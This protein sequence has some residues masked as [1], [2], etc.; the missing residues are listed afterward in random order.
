MA[1]KKFK[2]S[3]SLKDLLGRELVTDKYVAIFELVKNASDADATK[4]I[5]QF[6][7]NI[8]GK[9]SKIIIADNG[10]G[11]NA[12]D[13]ND[14]WLFVGYSDK[15]K[16]KDSETYVVSNK[17]NREYAGA[18]GVGRFSCDRL[19]KQLQMLTRQ[20][21]DKF[22][23]VLINWGDFEKNSLEEFGNVPISHIV[24]EKGDKL[25]LRHG[26]ILEISDLRDN[27]TRKDLIT[28]RRHLMKLVNP[29]SFDGERFSIEMIVPQEISEDTK[30]TH[31]YEKVNG[32]IKNFVLEKLNLKTI[33]I[34][35]SIDDK[36]QV[37]TTTLTDR[38]KEIYSVQEVNA[39]FPLL[40]N[41]DASIYHLNS[42][43]KEGFY[44]A[45]SLYPVNFGSIFVYKNGFR[46][47]PYGE[48]GDDT[49]GIDHRKQQGFLR[50]LGT[51]DVIGHV[52]IKGIQPDLSETTSRSGGII[53][54]Q[55]YDQFV[56]F[57]KEICLRRLEKYAVEVAKW[58]ELSEESEYSKLSKTERIATIIRNLIENNN[59]LNIHYNRD[60]LKILNNALESSA[61]KLPEQLA[62]MASSVNSK[63]VAEKLKKAAKVVKDLARARKVAEQSAA[64]LAKEKLKI[65]A[66]LENK[67]NQVI[68]LSKYKHPKVEN[69]ID[70]FHSVT[71]YSSAIENWIKR[72]SRLK[73]RGKLRSADTDKTLDGIA[74]ANKRI[75][76]LSRIIVKAN[77][78]PAKEFIVGD[79]VKY[80]SSYYQSFL[81]TFFGRQISVEC[82]R[83]S[84][85]FITRYSPLEI[86]LALDNLTY[87]ALK[88]RASKVSFAFS[89]ADSDTLKIIVSDDGNGLDPSI[90]NPSDIFLKG[91]STTD[92]AGWGLYQV[93]SM[94]SSINGSV[95]VETSAQRGLTFIITI[96][97]NHAK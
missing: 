84:I 45:M 61:E 95:S 83:N 72:Y 33:G 12:N 47:Y 23:K 31:E 19:G 43:A 28:L 80:I 49:L 44:R 4:V 70:C 74:E 10:I 14:K 75:H 9:C 2:I 76:T 92:G 57:I 22:N 36:G 52:N 25:D 78:N 58:G 32:P 38:G 7:Y 69:L 65:E 56:Q 20:N 51:R 5:I 21:K 16:Y 94:L 35:V 60:F 64:K 15:R 93:S 3:S 77:F 89:L 39:I 90:Q 55:T 85:V 53:K 79:I 17:S 11:M 63:D 27:W 68:F 24:S 97:K 26:T 29:F 66:E 40:H 59:I 48:P 82:Q 34:S 6:E 73:I 50:Y 30:T 41:I 87:N 71:A 54:N 67:E 18:K 46:I 91:F 1:Q 13:I 42:V 37:I 8:E 88:A 96:P 62:G 81:K 86:S